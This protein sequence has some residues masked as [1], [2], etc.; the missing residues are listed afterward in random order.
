MTKASDYPIDPASLISLLAENYVFPKRSQFIAIY[1][2][3]SKT[4][5]DS[6]LK[7]YLRYLYTRLNSWSLF[8]SHASLFSV[9]GSGTGT[10]QFKLRSRRTRRQR[11]QHQGC[12]G[13]RRTMERFQRRRN[14]DDHHQNGKVRADR[15]LRLKIRNRVVIVRYVRVYSY[16]IAFTPMVRV[17]RFDLSSP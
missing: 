8:S 14:R 11:S 2:C 10:E 4:I 3:F 12:F 13:Q 1:L 7:L 6:L 15:C 9:D 16:Q 5:G 17:N